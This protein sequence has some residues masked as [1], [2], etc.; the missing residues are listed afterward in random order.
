MK[1]SGSGGSA[2]IPKYE[3]N[4]E[5]LTHVM[6]SVAPG[7]DLRELLPNAFSPVEG[8]AKSTSVDFGSSPSTGE[9]SEGDEDHWAVV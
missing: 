8:E 9:G 6:V 4:E 1:N 7:G 3:E 2:A 5:E